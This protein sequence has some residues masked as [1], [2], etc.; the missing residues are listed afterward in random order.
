LSAHSLPSL[1]T[2]AIIAVTRCIFA[3]TAK[4]TLLKLYLRQRRDPRCDANHEKPDSGWLNGI[5]MPAVVEHGRLSADAATAQGCGI[6]ATSVFIAG[7]Q[8]CR[9][10]IDIVG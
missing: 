3:S 10:Y 8:A 7:Y 9:S 6:S 4:E 5:R 2:Y 1:T